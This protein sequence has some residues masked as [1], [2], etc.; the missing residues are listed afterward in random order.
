LRFPPAIIQLRRAQLILML[1]VL[2]PQ[3]LMTA[4]GIVLLAIGTESYRIFFGVAVL[5]FCTTAVTGYILVSIF[6][7]K[8]ASLARLQN[9][10]FS[11]ASHELRTPLT[12]IHLLLEPLATGK[13]DGEERQQVASLLSREVAR[14]DHL[15]VRTLDLSR[16][17]SGRHAFTMEPVRVDELVNEAIA[18]FD[19]ASL[20]RPTP[21]ATDLPSDLSVLGD[22]ATLV[23]AI[24][25]LL[26]NAWKYSGDDK[27][28]R[29]VARLHNRKIEIAVIDNGFGIDPAERH[30]L[31]DGFVRGK[32]ALE[33]RTPGVG[34]GLAIV[35]AIVRAHRG[36]IEVESAP[37][38]G[39]VF[40]LILPRAHPLPTHA[41]ALA[42]A[43]R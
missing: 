43:V 14:L 22:R 5:A 17:Q 4:A 19:A 40:R 39:S 30:E 29:V 6:V 16:M 13:L 36:K 8:G 26:I 41:A 7:G 25:N 32:A 15:L 28:I 21:I 20:G 2:V 34:L 38:H 33:S 42:P 11:S 18:A 31:F 27:Q 23:R 35:R 3:I 9:D 24:V 10:F 37:G 12:A 1:A